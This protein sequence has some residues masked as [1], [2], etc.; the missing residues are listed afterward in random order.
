MRTSLE[1]L[2][3]QAEKLEKEKSYDKLIAIYQEIANIYKAQNDDVNYEKYFKMSEEFLL[4]LIL[5]NTPYEQDI[6]RF[7][8]INDSF[9]NI[10]ILKE[11]Y[12]NYPFFIQ[13]LYKIAVLY[14]KNGDHQNA[15]LYY[16]K[17]INPQIQNS[18]DN[19]YVNALNSLAN[20][21]S[22]FY[23]NEKE[24]AHEYYLNAIEL[25][26]EIPTTRYN[27]AKLLES[28]GNYEDAKKN[29]LEAIKIN[30]NYPEAHNNLGLLLMSDNFNDYDLAKYHFEEAIK[31]N[32]NY[33]DAKTNFAILFAKLK[34]Y[35]K[36]KELLKNVIDNDGKNP[37]AYYNLGLLLSNSYFK[38]F[39]LAKQYYEKAIELNPNYIDAYINL[40][41]MLSDENFKDYKEAEKIFKVAIDRFA[42]DYRAYHNLAI[43]YFYILKDK[44][45]S[46]LYFAKAIEINKDSIISRKELA[47][48]IIG[49]PFLTKIFIQELRHLKD[50]TIDINKVE[51]KHLFIT[52]CNGSGKTTILKEC[53]LIL[54]K[55]L[56]TPIN[57]LFTEKNRK[58]IF[59]PKEYSL[60]LFFSTEKLTDVRI[61][62]ESGVYVVK[63]LGA[64]TGIAGDRSLNPEGVAK[65]EKVH[66]PFVNKIEDN[67]ADKIVAY[68]VD[69]DYSRLRAYRNNDKNVYEEI[70]KWFENFLNVLQSFD[71]KIVDIKYSD[72][73][74]SHD[75]ILKVKSPTNEEEII[76]VKFVEMPDGFKAAFKIVFELMLQMQTKVKTSYILPGI[77]MIDEPELFLHIKLQKKIMPALTQLFPNIQFIVATHSPFVLSSIS[78]AVIF[79][80]ETN[81]RLVDLSEVPPSHLSEYYF[82]FSKQYVEQIISKVEE[83]VSLIFLYKENK[84]SDE[85]KKQL[86]KL[87]I[88]LDE[89]TPYISDEYY[90]KFKENQEILYL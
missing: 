71:D 19:L 36:A 13:L 39:S 24:K 82:Q 11:I 40:G 1:E 52:G 64:N 49:S 75:F 14:H 60:R 58:E 32:P 44:E 34:E 69:L 55:L 29:Y 86:A 48:T 84:L 2:L 38:D 83:F 80:L 8:D 59:E 18:K 3:A 78:N 70:D 76:D 20:I 46:D 61:A 15:K 47:K 5:K 37:I 22:E 54:E 33:S 56:D 66:L 42:N 30:N 90:R 51:Q 67:L 4:K 27:L 72:E 10:E 62:Y 7:F 23:P 77:V 6:S 35:S 31:Q 21:I 53:K 16:E 50:L 57:E 65:I 45:N 17:F 28:L 26:P 12:S 25:S 89:V 9:E 88:E 73:N 43:L 74:N 81:R 79:D 41:I 63:Y 87:E 68:L 85:Q